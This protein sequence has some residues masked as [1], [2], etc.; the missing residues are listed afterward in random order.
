[1][2]DSENEEESGAADAGGHARNE[3]IP[4]KVGQPVLMPSR[5]RRSRLYRP[6]DCGES[7][8]EGNDVGSR[9]FAELESARRDVSVLSGIADEVLARLGRVRAELEKEFGDKSAVPVLVRDERQVGVEESQ[10]SQDG[11]GS[12]LKRRRRDELVVEETSDEEM[13]VVGRAK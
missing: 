12:P 11:S 7:R 8:N 10:R 13:C 4:G 1:M 5:R 2:R 6:C 9:M 3:A